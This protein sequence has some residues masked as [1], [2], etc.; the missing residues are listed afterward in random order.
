[1]LDDY[2]MHIFL[3]DEGFASWGFILKVL[4]LQI[5]SKASITKKRC[6]TKLA[7][8]EFEFG[9]VG[10]DAHGIADTYARGAIDPLSVYKSAVA[11]IEIDNEKLRGILRV[12]HNLG[13]LSAYQIITVRIVAHHC[14][15]IASDSD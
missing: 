8:I 6:A 4:S 14:A 7:Q 5:S 2:A 10:A 15:R 13:L 1:M 9:A 3:S 11:A 12:A